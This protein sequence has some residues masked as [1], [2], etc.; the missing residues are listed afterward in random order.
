MKKILLSVFTAFTLV[1]GLNAQNVTYSYKGSSRVQPIDTGSSVQF[2]LANDGNA[3]TITAPSA[4]MDDYKNV[5]VSFPKPISFAPGSG[6][7]PI[8]SIEL[9]S[10]Q[11]IA[12]SVVFIDNKGRTTDAPAI[13]SPPNPP[14]VFVPLANAPAKIFTYDFTNEFRNY[15]GGP[16]GT[17]LGTVDSTN[18][19]GL[20]FTINAGCY[21]AYPYHKHEKDSAIYRT[22]LKGGPVRIFRIQVGSALTTGIFDFASTEK[23]NTTISPNPST[24]NVK[25]SFSNVNSETASIS[26]VNIIGQEVYAAKTNS[27]TINLNLSELDKGVYFVRVSSAEGINVKRF[28]L[29]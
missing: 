2:T 19:V 18:I 29:N 21:G 1:L 25:V 13:L 22:S 20:S 6:N 27:S 3:F 5:K 23:Q 12:F 9:S 28:V 7:K 15:Y 24:G 14:N 4:G 16:N 10:T 17:A 11:Q 26:V 8:V